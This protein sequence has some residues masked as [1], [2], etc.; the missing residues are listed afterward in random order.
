[1]ARLNDPLRELFP[2]ELYADI[3]KANGGA[4]VLNAEANEF[5]PRRD[6][7][8]AAAQRIEDIAENE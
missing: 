8:L 3:P 6:A 2:L 1:M 5:H 4:D 7:A